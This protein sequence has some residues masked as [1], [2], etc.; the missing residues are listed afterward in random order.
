MTV[1][2]LAHVTI[3]ARY[4]APLAFVNYIMLTSHM[5]VVCH[6]SDFNSLPHATPLP[7][8]GL[9]DLMQPAAQQQTSDGSSSSSR[10]R[11]LNTCSSDA[12]AEVLRHLKRSYWPFPWD[13]NVDNPATGGQASLGGFRYEQLHLFTCASQPTHN[14][15]TRLDTPLHDPDCCFWHGVV[16]TFMNQ[17]TSCC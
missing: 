16:I 8:L 1:T 10:A 11:L 15:D 2:A 3:F 12:L 4:H 5:L 17:P 14:S 6:C 9:Q 13:T 7:N